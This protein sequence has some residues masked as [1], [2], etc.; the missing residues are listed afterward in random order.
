VV[1]R[2]ELPGLV[3]NRLTAA[4]LREAL[5]L[6]ADGAIG[7]AELDLVVARGIATGWIAA[8]VLRTELIGA[9]GASAERYLEQFGEPLEA[10][11]RS[12]ASWTSLDATRRARWLAAMREDASVAR[13]VDVDECTWAHA[14]ARLLR[15]PSTGD[16]T[17][18]A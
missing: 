2:R 6:V 16:A 12:L 13:D 5:D 14:L 1:I 4:L 8:G 7:A 3:A 18:D 11:W 15:A 9:G 10:L 17:S